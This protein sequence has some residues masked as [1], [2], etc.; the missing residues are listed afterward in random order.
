MMVLS[1]HSTSLYARRAFRAGANGYV[2]KTEP[3][4]QICKAIRD[5]LN[6]VPFV[7]EGVGVGLFYHG[8][9]SNDDLRAPA[10]QPDLL[11][12]SQP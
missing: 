11:F 1:M 6:G 3:T 7:S 2:A 12:E 9:R 5:V 8:T 4:R 10:S